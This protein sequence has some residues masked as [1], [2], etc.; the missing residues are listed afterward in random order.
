MA[1]DRS[2]QQQMSPCISNTKTCYLLTSANVPP[3]SRRGM[4]KSANKVARITAQ[5][6]VDDLKRGDKIREI[7][8]LGGHEHNAAINISTYVRYN[9]TSLKNSYGAG[10]SCSQV[11]STCIEWQTDRHDIIGF[12]L[13]NKLCKLGSTLRNR[14]YDV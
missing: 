14:G 11:I 2:L 13:E 8:S 12:H 5:H 3:P 4:Q 7:N 1:V 6:T 10:Q 9:S